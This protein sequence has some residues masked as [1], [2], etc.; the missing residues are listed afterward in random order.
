MLIINKNKPIYIDKN[1]KIIR[2]GN[3]PETGKELFYQDNNIITIF[4]NIQQP[5]EKNKLI[6]IIYNETRLEKNEIEI[7]IDYLISEKFII[8]HE[9]YEKVIKNTKYNRQNLFFSMFS[10]VFYQYETNFRDKKLLILGLGGI[11]ANSALL[12]SRS[13]FEK[14]ILVDCDKVETSNLI[15]QLPY[16][17]DDI[18]KLKTEALRNKIKNVNNDITIYNKNI[19]KKMI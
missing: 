1:K 15:R 13:G 9:Q 16:T 7:A 17:L 3:F 10:D 18:G 4:N 19:L 2:M 8:N 6:D 14:F 12:L 11:G 5:I